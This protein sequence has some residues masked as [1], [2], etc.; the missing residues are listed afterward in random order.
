MVESKWGREPH[1][2]IHPTFNTPTFYGKHVKYYKLTISPDEIIEDMKKK[3]SHCSYTKRMHNQH[4]EALVYHAETNNLQ[5]VWNLSHTSMCVTPEATN[6]DKQ[7]ILI[8]AA[9]NNNLE[10]IKA[11]KDYDADINKQDIYGK[12]ALHLATENEYFS[13]IPTLLD[14][15]NC[16]INITDN[17]GKTAL[18]ECYE[19]Q[20]LTPIQYALKRCAKPTKIAEKDFWRTMNA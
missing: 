8:I 14:Y 11:L 10:L 19:F 4:N 20:Q 2:L 6:K 12:T 18:E 13:I 9:K 7:T 5:A 17:S 15:R 16:D 3:I 1:V